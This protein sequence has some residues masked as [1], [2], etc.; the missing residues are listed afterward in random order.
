MNGG[1]TVLSPAREAVAATS[2][3]IDGDNISHPRG[4]LGAA[5]CALRFRRRGKEPPLERFVPR[6]RLGEDADERLILANGIEKG[7]ARQERVVEEPAVH[8]GLEA[9]QAPGPVAEQAMEAWFGL[10]SR[11]VRS[12]PIALS[13]CPTSV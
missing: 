2:H 11:A 7:V 10:I 12:N 1:P 5:I 4:R 9:E 6:L 13:D 8:R 3:P